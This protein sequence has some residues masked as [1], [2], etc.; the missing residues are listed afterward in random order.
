VFLL[1]PLIIL[2]K[3]G[4]LEEV[5]ETKFNQ[6]QFAASAQLKQLGINSA[7]ELFERFSK[8]FGC[9]QWKVSTNKE[10]IIA[11]GESCLLCSISKKIGTAQPC[12]MYCINPFKSLAK[13]L[14][15]SLNLSVNETLWN[16]HKCEFELKSSL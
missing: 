9:I 10:R 12:Y 8:I 14:E 13:A 15:P 16:G 5:T 4:I 2:K 7:E 11:M 1:I 3:P 6:Q